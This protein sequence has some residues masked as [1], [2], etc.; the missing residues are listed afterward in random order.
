MDQGIGQ[1][2]YNA[3]MAK[4]RGEAG[5]R[6]RQAAFGANPYDFGPAQPERSKLAMMA[7]K[8]TM[9]QPVDMVEAEG[10]QKAA[11][12]RQLIDY[13][14]RQKN[15]DE[16]IGAPGPRLDALSRGSPGGYKA[17]FAP[18]E[19]TQW[20]PF[21][22]PEM[23]GMTGMEKRAA[24]FA[25]GGLFKMPMPAYAM[26][27]PVMR[28]YAPGGP[29]TRDYGMG[30][31]GLRGYAMGGLVKGGLGQA[32]PN[33]RFMAPQML[34]PGYA[35]GGPVEGPGGPKD[36]LI[37]AK[38]S[39]GE[40]VMPAEAVEFY[41]L[42]RLHKMM[43]KAKEGLAEIKPA[44]QAPRSLQM[45]QPMP[46]MMGNP[47]GQPQ[48]TPGFAYGGM[49]ESMPRRNSLP[50]YAEGGLKEVDDAWDAQNRAWH[51]NPT[52]DIIDYF[53]DTE[54][55]TTSQA[56]NESMTVADAALGR[57][58]DSQNAMDQ[59]SRE[60]GLAQQK[61]IRDM[62]LMNDPNWQQA[63]PGLYKYQAE[64]LAQSMG[65]MAGPQRLTAVVGDEAY[66]PTMTDSPAFQPMMAPS[67]AAPMTFDPAAVAALRNRRADLRAMPTP[68]MA[69]GRQPQPVVASPMDTPMMRP[70][71]LTMTEKERQV[72]PI[73]RSRTPN[74]D[75]EA[76]FA[77]LTGMQKR[78]ARAGLQMEEATF[79]RNQTRAD[80]AQAVIDARNEQLRLQ[81]LQ[82]QRDNM[83][84]A[85]QFRL[86][87]ENR[88][89]GTTAALN[90]AQQKE[91]E[92]KA[93]QQAEQN[94]RFR[95]VLDDQGNPIPGRMMNTQGQQLNLQ[96][97]S[98]PGI[99]MMPVPGTRGQVIPMMGGSRVPG[100]PVM[101]A[102]TQPGPFREG[103]GRTTYTPVPDAATA[104]KAPS[105]RKTA[106]M[107]G[108]TAEAPQWDYASLSDGST[109]PITIDNPLPAQTRDRYM[110]Q[111]G[112]APQT[113]AE[114]TEAW[115]L[116]TGQPRPT[117]GAAQPT[118]STAPA[119]RAKIKSIT[120]VT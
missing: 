102:Q 70:A 63:N 94:R 41:G 29:G 68:A 15:I 72:M 16:A 61:R 45:P 120:P 78:R 79:Q 53:F 8:Y 106:P 4:E 33:G 101:Q 92:A 108:A 23:K 30:G 81:N 11:I 32:M 74:P 24:R 10:L 35:D 12:D 37:N 21:N 5:E 64:Q 116:T 54:G 71:P 48:P 117:A 75:F 26:G 96:T 1:A 109:R 34:S 82:D 112:R 2:S 6:Q 28:N 85:D 25:D 91:A 105:V 18:K 22:N 84:I 77:G 20:D 104:P 52:P 13:G 119:T 107:K 62:E 19:K 40:F 73:S 110:H 50:G 83:V 3:R 113:E 86:A 55:Q 65:P 80:A 36:D 27:G 69:N 44:P 9:G 47:M 66:G 89:I 93:N 31:P 99:T 67:P 115:Y 58:F 17:S 57:F 100:M 59:Q 38:L 97:E 14:L 95:P 43:A 42:D 103:L 76:A 87:A 49:M 88:N 90:A 60:A 46:M 118:A 39:D 98:T 111:Y 7:D 56:A 51:F 114:W